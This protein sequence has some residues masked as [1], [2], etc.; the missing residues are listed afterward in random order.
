MKV[1]L[2]DAMSCYAGEAEIDQMQA[3]PYCTLTPPPS[4][5]APQVAH[6]AG[7]AWMVLD[8][9]PEPLPKSAVEVKE[10]IVQ[11]TQK[12]LD[13]FAKTRNYDGILSACTYATSTVPKFQIEGRYCVEARDST[14]ARLYQILDEVGADT[15]PMPTGYADIEPELPA[16]IW[17]N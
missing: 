14:W 8:K 13:D 6:F 16:L 12:R 15:R 10:E 4:V 3:L 1:Y 5:T 7:A 9:Y 17:P 11:S 2:L